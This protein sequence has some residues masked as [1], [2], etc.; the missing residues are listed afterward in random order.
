MK[1]Y[2]ITIENNSKL[3]KA[4]VM[5][6]SYKDAMTQACKV[7]PAGFKVKRVQENGREQH[8]GFRGPKGPR[9]ALGGV[10]EAGKVYKPRRTPAFWNGKK[11]GDFK[12]C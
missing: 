4:V 5:A 12:K 3:G 8:S 7:C 6:K 2:T 9:C 11:T 10:A 1:A